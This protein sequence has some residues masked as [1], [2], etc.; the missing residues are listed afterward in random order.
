MRA[1]TPRI[2]LGGALLLACAIIALWRW[3]T[4]EL[5]RIELAERAARKEIVVPA[6]TTD[7]P[8]PPPPLDETAARATRIEIE[9]V[10]Q[11]I[12]TL[13][14]EAAWPA[15]L[16]ALSPPVAVVST[17]SPLGSF[18]NSGR[19][20]PTHTIHTLF[21]AA[22]AGNPDAIEALLFLEPEARAAAE[23]LFASLPSARAQHK[24][25]EAL[26]A[27]LVAGDL[28]FQAN[29]VAQQKTNAD[30]ATVSVAYVRNG[31]ATGAR[32]RLRR[33][34]DVW[35]LVVP[36]VAVKKY[37]EQLRGAGTAAGH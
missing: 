36:V 23:A 8:A 18:Y 31:E 3:K 32:L 25:P 21:W 12:V 6:P 20:A 16:P 24:S 34:N 10:R 35:R 19:V 13:Q 7:L 28:S 4:G 29:I 30:E 37:A 14:A 1:S 33:V 5:L 2:L 26:L 17:M 22:S 9:R 11:Q 27:L 15:T